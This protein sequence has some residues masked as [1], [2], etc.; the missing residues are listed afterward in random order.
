LISVLGGI[1]CLVFSAGI[2]E[3][4]PEIR[5]L[6]CRGLDWLGISLD[7]EANREGHDVIS[8]PQSR[9]AVMVVPTDEEAMIARQSRD[10]LAQL[11]P[12]HA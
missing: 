8:L 4:S 11:K 3:H 1:D 12:A 10:I 6:V 5:T 7:Q 2:G 9:V